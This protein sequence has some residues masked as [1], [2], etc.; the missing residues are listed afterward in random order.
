MNYNNN[1]RCFGDCNAAFL[2]GGW[3][4]IPKMT[5]SC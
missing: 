3:D 2:S 1:G 4:E 5:A